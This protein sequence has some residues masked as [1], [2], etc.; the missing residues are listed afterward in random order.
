MRTALIAL[1][2]WILPLTAF[3]A[4]IS[5]LDVVD[6]LLRHFERK[7]IPVMFQVARCESQFQQTDEQGNPLKGK[8]TPLDRGLFQISLQ[9]HQEELDRRGLNVHKLEDN[10]KFASILYYRNGLSDWKASKSCWGLPE[11]LE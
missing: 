2:L 7:D 6:I 11:P 10:V 9:W 8:L 4:P 3:G 1:T 5:N